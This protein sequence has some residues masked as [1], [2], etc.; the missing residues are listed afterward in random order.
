VVALGAT[1]AEV[2]ERIREALAAY[3]EDLRDRG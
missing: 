1:R 3:S 2:G